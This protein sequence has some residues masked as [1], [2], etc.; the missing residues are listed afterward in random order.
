VLD[1]RLSGAF[2]RSMSRRRIVLGALG[3]LGASALAACAAP[4]SPTPAPAK[5]G[6]EGTP[7]PKPTTAPAAAPPQAPAATKPAAAPPTSAPAA[8]AAAS[9]T[10][11][12]KPAE[13]TKPAEAAKPAAA[14]ATGAQGEVEFWYWGTPTILDGFAKGIAAFEQANPR[15]KVKPVTSPY[16][17]FYEKLQATLAG[18]THPD[19]S[20]MEP[21]NLVTYQKR[22]FIR[23]FQPFVQDLDLSKYFRTLFDDLNRIPYGKTGDLWGLP[24]YQH[25][26]VLIY[27]KDLFD[28]AGV[29]YPDGSWTW[30]TWEDTAAKLTGGGNYGWSAGSGLYEPWIGMIQLGSDML[31]EKHEKVLF[32]S[33]EGVKTVQHLANLYKSGSG[34]ANAELQAMNVPLLLTGKVAMDS[35]H[36]WSLTMDAYKTAKVNW[37]LAPSPARV[38]EGSPKACMGFGDSVILYSK[39]KNSDGAV[40]LSKALLNDP[41]QSEI[42]TSWGLLPVLQSAMPAFLKNAPQGKSFAA[43]SEQL[44]YMRTFQVTDDF[45][46][47]TK[48]ITG[49]I[50]QEIDKKTPPEQIAK[51]LGTKANEKLKEILARP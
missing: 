45:N 37:D 28:K 50:F 32:D 42:V 10:A 8:A 2:C 41:F 3:A 16:N 14:P 35:Q 11:A 25:T 24:L 34:V 4:A 9:P 31:D 17:G 26:R 22:Q 15:L 18:G 51:S 49:S 48:E 47:W 7:A 33:P 36:T 23:S 29:K 12:A 5:P 38:G 21:L 30:Q 40:A 43:A 20:M 6:P 19:L 39:A 27:N 46:G 44:A 13:A 1:P